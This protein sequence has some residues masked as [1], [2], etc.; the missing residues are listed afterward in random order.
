MKS[1]KV[2]ISL[3]ISI[4]FATSIFAQSYGP[5]K[6]KS[7]DPK[8]LKN[9]TLLIPFVEKIPEKNKDLSGWKAFNTDTKMENE[10]KRRVEEAMKASSFDF[11][12]FEVKAFNKDVIKKEKDRLSAVLFFE[13][14]F[15]DNWYVK[16]AIAEP[17]WQE[18]AT[19][20]INGLM[21]SDIPDLTFM[22][23]ML[24]YSLIQT[25]AAY[26]NNF[27]PLYRGHEL[28][29][30][31]R[32][33]AFMDDIREK[34]FLVE[35]LDKKEKGFAK[36]NEKMNEYLKLDWKFTGFDFLY[37]KEIE[38]KV[39]EGFDGIYMHNFTIYTANP[40]IDYQYV[41]FVTSPGREVLYW[42]LIPGQ[43]K[44]A[45]IKYVQPK[46]DDWVLYFMDSKKRKSYEELK[47]KEKARAKTPAPAP[48][49]PRSSK[50]GS[51]K[52]KSE[53]PGQVKK[54]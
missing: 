10:W 28:K 2:I 43:I 31:A 21:L 25:S 3:F 4:L 15:Y 26:D 20:P 22:F 35:K 53:K 52:G 41:V 14:D 16:M 42:M 27:R 48:K 39:A 8:Y 18:I 32:I 50:S 36:K 5:D 30:K 17:K 12:K 24:Q 34:T 6:L 49:A 54:R 1:I 7:V 44:P 33:D 46:I 45:N 13:R 29:Y 23:N 51:S 37:K 47:A 9:K 11:L 19:A 38:A 40:K